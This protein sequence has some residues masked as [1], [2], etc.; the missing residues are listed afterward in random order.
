MESRR[1][2]SWW[3]THQDRGYSKPP[4]YSPDLYFDK[5]TNQGQ[6]IH[7]KYQNSAQP[8]F[9]KCRCMTM[10]GP[11]RDKFFHSFSKPILKIFPNLVKTF[12]VFLLAAQIPE[13]VATVQQ[14]EHDRTNRGMSFWRTPNFKFFQ[15]SISP[16]VLYK[17]GLTITFSLHHFPRAG[18]TTAYISGCMYCTSE[19]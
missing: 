18:D 16:N 12:T 7:K 11:A 9:P 10:G 3:C 4:G 15:G 2:C 1:A 19:T 17:C 5:N 13:N 14:F 8:N 6:Y